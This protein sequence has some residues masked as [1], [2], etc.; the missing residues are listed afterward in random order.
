LFIL[1]EKAWCSKTGNEYYHKNPAENI[2][3]NQKIGLLPKWKW[4]TFR[5]IRDSLKAKL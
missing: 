4:S 5:E 2:R 3:P 1:L